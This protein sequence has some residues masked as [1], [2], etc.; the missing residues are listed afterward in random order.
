MPNIHIMHQSAMSR[1]ITIASCLALS[2]KVKLPPHVGREDKSKYK[3]TEE[4]SGNTLLVPF[5]FCHS[6]ALG[7]ILCVLG[8]GSG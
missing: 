2:I 5:S 1:S 8:F 7:A 3:I 6:L 4:Q